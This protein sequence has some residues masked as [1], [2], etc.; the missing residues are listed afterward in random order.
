MPHPPNASPALQRAYMLIGRLVVGWSSAPCQG[1][2][3]TGNYNSHLLAGR[4]LMSNETQQPQP[5]PTH[6]RKVIAIPSQLQK[7]SHMARCTKV[8]TIISG[9]CFIQGIDA[10]VRQC[11]ISCCPHQQQSHASQ[12]QQMCRLHYRCPRSHFHSHRAM[13][14][15]PVDLA[16]VRRGVQCM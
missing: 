3:P 5:P 10:Q 8:H 6:T 1:S 11:S 15:L 16:L 4:P 2:K 12:C 9:T 7:G 13:A 14:R